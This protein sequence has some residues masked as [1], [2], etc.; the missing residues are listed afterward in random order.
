MKRAMCFWLM[1][2]LAWTAGSALA[3]DFVEKK[4]YFLLEELEE[5]VFLGWRED[6]EHRLIITEDTRVET[7]TPPAPGMFVLVQD[8]SGADGLTA[9]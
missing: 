5:G 2:A 8:K 1:L 9:V 6:G 4:V 7:A 3:N